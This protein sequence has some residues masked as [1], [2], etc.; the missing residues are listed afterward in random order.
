MCVFA[1]EQ[2]ALSSRVG[3]RFSADLQIFFVSL[4]RAIHRR[5]CLSLFF[6]TRAALFA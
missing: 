3:R 6:M 2:H 4:R 1:E 5:N